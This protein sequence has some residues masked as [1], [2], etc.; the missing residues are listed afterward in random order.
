MSKTV[1]L[2]HASG[3]THAFGGKRLAKLLS[4][5]KASRGGSE[6]TKL[7]ENGYHETLGGLDLSS[8]DYGSLNAEASGNFG[9]VSDD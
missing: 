2:R 4:E 5:L 8:I 9:H 7:V 6:I 3:A 1:Y